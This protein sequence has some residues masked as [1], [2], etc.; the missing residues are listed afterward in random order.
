MMTSDAKLPLKP[1]VSK[2]M[3]HAVVLRHADASL[4]DREYKIL[5]DALYEA[6]SPGR[7][8]EVFDE[9]R[10]ELQANSRLLTYLEMKLGAQS[11]VLPKELP[12]EFVQ[13]VGKN[14]I[15]SAQE[16]RNLYSDI[17]EE[18]ILAPPTS[19]RPADQQLMHFYGVTTMEA[20]V[21]AMDS[22]IT[23]LQNRLPQPHPAIVSTPRQG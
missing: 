6:L 18:W 17:R 21:D 3:Q 23:R 16:I 8:N 14:G 22:H 20:L 4:Y 12:D 19:M 13:R 1:L 10:T 15:W 7:T 9:I 5:Q 11:Q 2:L